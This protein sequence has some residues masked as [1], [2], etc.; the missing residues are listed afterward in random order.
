[1]RKIQ[2]MLIAV[3]LVL[4]LV[5]FAWADATITL[6]GTLDPLNISVVVDPAT[7]DFSL[8]AGQTTATQTINIQNRTQAPMKVTLTSL[9]LDAN[10]WKPETNWMDT[11]NFPVLSLA[12]AQRKAAFGIEQSQGWNGGWR[13]SFPAPTVRY[14][15]AGDE[16]TSLYQPANISGLDAAGSR[17]GGFTEINLGTLYEWDNGHGDMVWGPTGCLNL[18]L[19]ADKKR[20]TTKNLQGTLTLAFEL[21]T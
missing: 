14:V 17:Y 4:N 7:L 16:G 1:M 2:I 13:D 5:C 20:I 9:T 8:A 12:D 11:E 19:V 3:L 15:L 6:T 18:K 10:S 21:T